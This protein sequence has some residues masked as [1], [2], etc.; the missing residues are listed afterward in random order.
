MPDLL[1]TQQMQTMLRVDRTTIYRM[2]KRGDLPAVRV[3]NQWRF[4]KAEVD[5]WLGHPSTPAPAGAGPGGTDS[6]AEAPASPEAARRPISLGT[7]PFPIECIQPIQDTFAD[8]LGVSIVLADSSGRALTRISNPA[9]LW[10]LVMGQPGIQE[11]YAGFWQ[12]LGRDPS[13]GARLETDPVGLNWGRGLIRVGRDLRGI[14]AVGGLAPE[15]WPPSGAALDRL[16]VSTGL[17]RSVLEGHLDQVHRLEP[18]GCRR[19]MPY[20]GRISDIMTHIYLER[21]DILDRF[22]TIQGLVDLRS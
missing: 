11:E 1:T 15:G 22:A 17:D 8:L 7:N 20:V 12:R 14:V 19:L 9:G 13:L 6:P 3:G 21:V 2:A 18:A 10:E 5:R 16:A 4:P